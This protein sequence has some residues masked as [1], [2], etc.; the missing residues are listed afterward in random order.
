M[1]LITKLKHVQSAAQLHAGLACT[2]FATRQRWLAPAAAL[3]EM[4]CA[5]NESYPKAASSEAFWWF[6]SHNQCLDLC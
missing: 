5:Y 4:R 1:A 2:A 3:W 6:V